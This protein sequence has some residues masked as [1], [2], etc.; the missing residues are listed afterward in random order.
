MG[1]I[2]EKHKCLIFGLKGE[3]L[4]E[5]VGL[6]KVEVFST[7][8]GKVLVVDG[9][10][11]HSEKDE[12]FYH[13]MLVH[14]P[15]LLHP[16]PKKI[17]IIGGGDGGAA[18]E[19]LKH[20]PDEVL[21]IEIDRNVIEVCKKYLL[22]DNGALDKVNIIFQDGFEFVLD[23]EEQFDVIIVDSSDPDML[24]RS[25]V[26]REFYQACLKIC[27]LLV[28]QSQ[29]PFLQ[30]DYFTSILSNSMP[31]PHRSVYVSFVPSYPSGMWSFLL[32]SKEPIFLDKN[33]IKDRFTKRGIETVY[34]TPDVHAAAF[35]LPKWLDDIVKSY[36]I[37]H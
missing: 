10:I 14:V 27:D 28:T 16:N 29:S 26:S 32:C 11:Q 7:C 30:E 13:E 1:E 31:F 19:T 35:V 17:L 9:K 18:R 22:I 34:Y 6:Q 8:L 12:S 20:H 37:G 21:L 33:T 15:L 4:V 36:G 2:V 25:L 5:K 3:K 23:C 24:S